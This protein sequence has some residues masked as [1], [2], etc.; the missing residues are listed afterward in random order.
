MKKKTES[1][2]KSRLIVAALLTGKTL[3]SGEIALMVSK[4][5]K[6]KI[7][8]QD[9]A[10]MLSKIT[11]SKRCDLG[12]FIRKNKGENG[13]VYTM[14]EEALS[15]TEDKAYGLTL[16]IGPD[17]YMLEEAL[18]D[19]PGLRKYAKSVP[20]T[21]KTVAEKTVKETVKG[22]PEKRHP[23]RPPKSAGLP[24]P[25]KAAAD[26]LSDAKALEELL[27]RMIRKAAG[28][29]DMD[30]VVKVSFGPEKNKK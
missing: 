10:S 1:K 29:E 25:A 27:L 8:I 5:A 18:E 7:K 9:V 16:K 19:F 26:V 2:S 22:T 4:A 23:G 14:V 17:K 21:G 13:F 11:D 28:S 30:L 24:K 15:L 12:L 20:E 6:K 3:T